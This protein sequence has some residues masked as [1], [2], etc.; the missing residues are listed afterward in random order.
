MN[1]VEK[2]PKDM[3]LPNLGILLEASQMKKVLQGA[4]F[5]C[6]SDG[7]GIKPGD[8]VQEITNC[9]IAWVKYK[10]G[11]NCTASYILIL[12]GD[13][14]DRFKE[15]RLY[16]RVYPPGES[17][18]RFKRERSKKLTTSVSGCQ[19]VHIPEFDMIAW[20]FPNDRKLNGLQTLLDQ[21]QLIQSMLPEIISS[22]LGR[23]YK[24]ENLTHE[25]VHYVPE[26]TCT[27]RLELHIRN[28]NTNDRRSYRIFGKTYYDNEGANTYKFMTKLWQKNK[29]VPN[30]VE[31]AEPLGYFPKF[32]ILFQAN[33]PGH[34]LS[35]TDWN[36]PSFLGLIKKAAATVARLHNS[37]ITCSR[38][39]DHH[40]WINRLEEIRQMLIRARPSIEKILT[41]LVNSLQ[42][43]SGQLR[44]TPLAV[45]HGD[46]HCKNFFNHQG[47]VSLIDLDNHCSGPPGFDLG[48]FFGAILYQGLLQK[49]EKDLISKIVS[50]F[51]S[52]YRKGVPWEFSPFELNWYISMALVN[53]RAY[54]SVTR[55]KSGR[56]DILDIL[57]DLA[58]RI[59]K[60]EWNVMQR[61]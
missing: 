18:S 46:L 23:Q 59:C 16:T 36:R 42:K 38:S 11:K 50:S 3:R 53:E 49:T 10:P 29:Q 39:V 1:L 2:I 41:P 28:E 32:R 6:Y 58:H 17:Q 54:R 51:Y 8:N 19:L 55:L 20:I 27:V 24:I 15:Q 57:I 31:I 5:E 21:D 12:K 7:S 60:G 9:Q 30:P 61:I 48:S 44:D 22:R 33:L 40:Y 45:L 25:I 43:Q 34:C 4:L 14:A 26:H 13:N 37:K 35:E 52:E 47:K 56:L